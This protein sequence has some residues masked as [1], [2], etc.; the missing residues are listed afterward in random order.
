MKT[1][2]IGVDNSFF[3]ILIFFL[4]GFGVDRISYGFKYKYGFFRM[5]E[6]VRIR[7][8]IGAEADFLISDNMCLCFVFL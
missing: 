7:T 1:N 2:K 8:D 6:M 3:Y 5:L 4:I